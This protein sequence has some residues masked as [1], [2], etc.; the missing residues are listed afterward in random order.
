MT[1]YA[2]AQ[3]FATPT[4]TFHG[5]GPS[6]VFIP[7][8]GMNPEATRMIQVEFSRNP[9]KFKVNQYVQFVPGAGQAGYYPEID[10][11]EAVRVVNQEDYIWPDGDDAPDLGLRPL[12]WLKY[13]TER[14]AYPFRLGQKTVDNA[15][16]DIMGSHGRMAATKAMTD[17]SLDAV[18]VMTTEANWPAAHYD[19][20]VDAL[21][22]TTG[23]SW[24]TSSTTNLYI[25]QS[26]HAIVE[27]IL[28]AT[29]GVVGTDDIA[30]VIGP[31]TAHKMSRTAEV[32]GYI[33]NNESSV[34][35]W[36][37]TGI[38][39]SYNLPPKMY[40]VS[41]VVEDAVRVSTRRGASTTTRAFLMGDNAVFAS[42]VGGL[43][44]P[45]GGDSG[46]NAQPPNFSTV[47]GFVNEDMTIESKTDD[48]NRRQKGRVVD[49]RDIVLAA[50]ISGSQ[51][52]D[53]TT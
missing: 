15:Q 16:Y 35:F 32:R 8:A 10:T 44:A 46:N 25:Q 22:S 45:S 37:N 6:N 13:V 30:C 51:I 20:T 38:F 7:G 17:R 1:R 27:R 52:A 9:A 2:N 53:V 29:G 19:A 21:L 39:A 4:T 49:D 43:I 40:G 33:V 18:T 14:R 42:R 34:P 3:H 12:R 26:F 41:I 50:P 23:A 47:V 36:Q 5:P 28:L 31:D 48:W 11:D 24:V